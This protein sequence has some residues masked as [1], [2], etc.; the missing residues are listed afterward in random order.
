MSVVLVF[1]FF[2]AF[3]IIHKML[4]KTGAIPPVPTTN[5]IDAI[6]ARPRPDLVAGFQLLGNVRYH[7]GHTWALSE[8]PSL[9][10]VGIDD[11]AAKVLG[12]IERI[13]LPKRG[14][15]IRQGQRLLTM[16]RHGVSIGIASPI[17][18]S[19]SEVNDALAQDPNLAC[20][21]PYGDGWVVAVH[22][23]DARINFRNLLGGAMARGWIEEAA[24]LL[25]RRLDAYSGILAQDGGIAVD[26]LAEHIPDADFVA[27][28]HELFLL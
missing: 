6:P 26:N 23:P 27:L 25:R 22:S 9:V 17:E 1:I 28:A 2:I 19:V 7:P 16:Q 13:T 15:W 5:R 12:R 14:Q 8:S 10:R 21:D 20:R 18:G 3:L 24:A 11:F 4:L